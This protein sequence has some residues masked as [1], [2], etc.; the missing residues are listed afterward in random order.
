[1]D[2]RDEGRDAEQ[3]DIELIEPHVQYKPEQ[4]EDFEVAH[5]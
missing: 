1:M 5:A 3:D 2:A 4:D